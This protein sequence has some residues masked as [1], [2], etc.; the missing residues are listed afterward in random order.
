MFPSI[1]LTI[2]NKLITDSYMRYIE[3]AFVDIVLN[4]MNIDGN[5]LHT[6]MFNRILL[7]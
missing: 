7:S 6:G 4:K 2:E 1:V 5:M 3:K